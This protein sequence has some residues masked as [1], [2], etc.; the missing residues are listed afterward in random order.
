MVRRL[1][2]LVLLGSLGCATAGGGGVGLTYT[3][4]FQAG[5]R[6]DNRGHLVEGDNDRNETAEP[7]RRSD[8]VT[9]ITW[10]MPEDTPPY[11][12]VSLKGGTL[13]VEQRLGETLPKRVEDAFAAFKAKNQFFAQLHERIE[14]AP[15][16]W[17]APVPA[18][19][20]LAEAGNRQLQ[21]AQQ[22]K[23]KVNYDPHVVVCVP[24]S[25]VTERTRHISLTILR[26]DQADNYVMFWDL[27]NEDPFK[28]DGVSR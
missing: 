7:A 14:P 3:N 2:F 8:Y 15:A 27:A 4:A 1:C 21:A 25:P 24:V 6:P 28:V 5:A 26:A 23:H 20:T 10:R 9:G 19:V 16:A 18:T 12:F 13:C 11:K 22:Y 17:P